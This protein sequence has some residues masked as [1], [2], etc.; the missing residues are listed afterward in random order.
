VNREAM[1]KRNLRHFYDSK[2]ASK[3]VKSR[4]GSKESSSH[5]ELLWGKEKKI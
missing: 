3:N 2:K 1:L 4:F 5:G